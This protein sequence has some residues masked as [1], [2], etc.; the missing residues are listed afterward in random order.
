MPEGISNILKLIGDYGV[1]IIICGIFLYAVI[2]LLGIGIKW[3]KSRTARTNHDELLDTRI[4]AGQR[5]HKLIGHT[6]EEFKAE[7]IQVMEFS[8]SV[9]SVAYLPFR[10]MTCTYEVYDLDRTAT[11]YKLDRIS[12]SL[13][14]PFFQNLQTHSIYQFNSHHVSDPCETTL[15]SMMDADEYV[16]CMALTTVRGKMIGYVQATLKIK[17]TTSEITNF[18]MMGSR[19]AELLGAQDK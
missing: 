1:T 17:F 14:S 4:D 8:N 3:L 18:Q 11:G 9:M 6:L 5:I 10:Y 13:F 15:C 12:T 7:R 2:Q 16:M 19:I